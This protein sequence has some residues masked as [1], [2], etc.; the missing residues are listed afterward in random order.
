[1]T[2]F[3]D[4]D[5]FLL[6]PQAFSFDFYLVELSQCGVGGIDLIR[7]IRKR[8]SAGLVALASGDQD[9]FVA[10]LASG[11][12]MVVRLDAPADHLQAGIAAVRRRVLMSTPLPSGRQ[13]PW[14]LM[15]DKS[16]LQAPDG[17]RIALSE[18]DLAIMQ[19]FAA[20]GGAKVERQTLVD[21]LWG[22]GASPVGDNVLHAAVYRLRK[23]IE[24]SGHAMVPVHAVARVGYEFRAPLVRG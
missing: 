5:D 14:T 21:R 11:A 13:V 22:I 9:E 10:A 16:L 6:S 8:S 1:M 3:E 20:A 7:L 17:K 23:R 2:A 19:C 15:E 12:D 4:S 24:Q 18:S